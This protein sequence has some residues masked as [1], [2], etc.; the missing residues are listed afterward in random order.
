MIFDYVAAAGIG[1]NLIGT[2]IV[3]ASL[4]LLRRSSVPPVEVGNRATAIRADWR[5]RAAFAL[6]LLGLLLQLTAIL[7]S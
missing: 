2:I 5:F 6:I 4:G 3:A 7:A 1:L